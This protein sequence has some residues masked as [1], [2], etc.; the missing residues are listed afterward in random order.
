VVF[1]SGVGELRLM[2]RTKG[3]PNEVVAEYK[4]DVNFAGLVGLSNGYLLFPTLVI[5]LDEGILF[6][7]PP[8]LMLFSFLVLPLC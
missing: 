2:K 5:G 1:S 8:M 7:F 3:A 6:V 4:N